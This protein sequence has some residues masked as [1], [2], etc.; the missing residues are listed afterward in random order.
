MNTQI[1][2]TFQVLP[3]LLTSE[4]VCREL[5]VSRVTLWRLI[6][7]GELKSIRVG[8]RCVRIARDELTAFVGRA[9]ADQDARQ[10]PGGKLSRA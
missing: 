10:N 6:R 7:D 1:S 3:M 2:K 9:Q 5:G 8:R 4:Q